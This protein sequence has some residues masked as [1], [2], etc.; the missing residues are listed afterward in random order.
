MYF[1]KTLAAA[2]AVTLLVACDQSATAPGQTTEIA[3][4]SALIGGGAA[5]GDGGPQPAIVG[6][7][8]HAALAK[9]AHDNSPDS[10]RAVAASLKT[11]ITAA[12]DA[13]A[14]GDSVAA[15]A[16]LQAVRQA[17]ARIIV[18]ALGTDVVTKTLAFATDRVKDL[19]D[20]IAKADPSNH[21]LPRLK[22]LATSLGQILS[23]ANAAVAAGDNVTALLDAA[24]VIE[25][26]H[27]VQE[28]LTL[29]G[30]GGLPLD[31]TRSRRHP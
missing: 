16:A 20:R 29:G 25:A 26:L 11:L 5:F 9:I 8:M 1:R 12:H 2:A 30:A 17:E 22:M 23:D 31:T 6:R 15:R 13:H 10:A 21:D 27:I 14:A 19:N 18:G 7:L 28:H 3:I 4:Q 24:R